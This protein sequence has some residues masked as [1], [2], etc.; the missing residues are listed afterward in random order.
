MTALRV[1]EL[2]Q[3]LGGAVEGDGAVEVHRMAGL[4]EALAGDLSFLA[5]PR[6]AAE[7]AATRASAVIVPLDWKGSGQPV[8]IRVKDPDRAFAQAAQWLGRPAVKRAPA[9]HPTAIIAPDVVLG[10]EL[11]VGPY[12]VIEAGAAI[13]ERTVLEA[14][15]FVGQ[16]CA[17]GA[18][19]HFYPHVSV[20]EY[21]RIGARVVLHNGVV[22]GSD[23]FGYL[24]A[25]GVWQKI[26][27]VGIVV[28]GDDVEIGANT[29]VDRAR[30]GETRIENGV[31]IDNLVQVA[32]NVTIGEHSAIAGQTGI[33]GSSH[34][35]KRVRVGGQV[36]IS[37]HLHLGDDV[38]V[39]AQSGVSK[40][41]APRSYIFGTPAIPYDKALK[42]NAH[43][44]RLPEW[45]QK[46]AEL[47]KRIDKLEK[48]G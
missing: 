32:H 10:R 42:L 43:L 39:G 6:Y 8:L 29:A 44:H 28:V 4:V 9:I 18:D 36:G 17:I 25:G 7:M 20:R 21:C 27:Q 48:S 5:H 15:V 46:V 19:C 38:V 37:G 47:E 16:Q 14:G 35:G 41:I 30:F 40:D 45:K 26:P 12:C 31:K 2:A 13:G 11:F 33:A 1:I 24:N 34:L 3:R 23:G 22:I